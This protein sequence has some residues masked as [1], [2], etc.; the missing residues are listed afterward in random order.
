MI[1]TLAQVALGGALGAMGRYLTSV[2][3]VRLMGHGFPWGTLAVNIAG[4]FLMGVLVVVLGKKGGMHLA[5]LMVTGMLG[6]FTTFSTFS[7]D[8][9]TIYERGQLGLA[10][11]YAA[12]SVILSLG[13]I[14]LA[15]AVTRGAFA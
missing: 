12:A 14:A 10:A 2:A 15:L 9:L 7:L 11:G 8:V 6:G 3:A 5:P 1:W 4:S 13:A